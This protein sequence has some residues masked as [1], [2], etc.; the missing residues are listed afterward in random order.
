LA[1][2]FRLRPGD[3]P[4]FAEL[5]ISASAMIKTIKSDCCEKN[6][7]SDFETVSQKNDET[8]F[9]SFRQKKTA[10]RKKKIPSEMTQNNAKN[11]FTF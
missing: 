3:V 4:R 11:L 1:A 2:Q 9:L 8:D 10:K 7:E 6:D 5:A